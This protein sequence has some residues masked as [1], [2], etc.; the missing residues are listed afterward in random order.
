MYEQSRTSNEGSDQISAE[1]DGL[2]ESYGNADRDPRRGDTDL[3]L[4]HLPSPFLHHFFV[5]PRVF[6]LVLIARSWASVANADIWIWAEVLSSMHSGKNHRLLGSAI[7]ATIAV[8]DTAMLSAWNLTQDFSLFNPPFWE[9]FRD[10]IHSS[11]LALPAVSSNHAMSVRL[12]VG[13]FGAASIFEGIW[14]F[15]TL[16]HFTGQIFGVPLRFEA[17]ILTSSMPHISTPTMSNSPFSLT[18]TFRV[19]VAAA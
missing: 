18:L 4:L 17:D 6:R 14:A 9:I 15:R 2:I 3:P 8:H 12:L 13:F 5:D 19:Q 11:L 1:S 16:V 10:F 7:L